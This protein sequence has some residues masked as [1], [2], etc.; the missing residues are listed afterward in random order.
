[1]RMSGLPTAHY[2]CRKANLQ[3]SEDNFD[4]K[5]TENAAALAVGLSEVSAKRPSDLFLPRAL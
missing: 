4:A 3:V 5:S 2:S 1:M